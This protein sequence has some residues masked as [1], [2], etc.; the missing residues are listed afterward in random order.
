[1][2]SDQC[3]VYRK[4]PLL[5]SSGLREVEGRKNAIRT[6]VSAIMRCRTPY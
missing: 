1:M 5:E 3:S 6:I 2:H 4:M